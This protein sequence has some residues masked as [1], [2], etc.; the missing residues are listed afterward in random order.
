M[1]PDLGYSKHIVPCR[2][3][4]KEVTSLM[5]REVVPAVPDMD[6]VTEELIQAFADQFGFEAFE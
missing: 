3:A 5:S 6:M 1:D 4:N 2:I